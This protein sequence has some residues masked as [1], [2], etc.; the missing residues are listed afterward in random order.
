MRI[1]CVIGCSNSTLKLKKWQQNFCEQHNCNFGVGRCI[2]DPPFT[3]HSFPNKSKDPELRAK[4]IKLINR[5]EPTGKNWQPQKDSRICSEHFELGAT[6]PSLKLGYT[7]TNLSILKTRPPP[8]A[9]DLPQTINSQSNSRYNVVSSDKTNISSVKLPICQPTSSSD[10]VGLDHAYCT[11]EGACLN[12]FQQ[13]EKITRLQNEINNL[14]KKKPLIAVHNKFTKTDSKVRSN[15]GMPNRSALF[16]LFNYLK[17]RAAKL[18]YWEGATK[19]ISTKV[20]RHFPPN[21]TGPSQ[22]LFLMDEFVLVLLKLRLDIKFEFLAGLFN[23]SQ[24]TVS[25]IFNTWIKFLA[26]E[27][28]PLIF[29]PSKETIQQMQ[30]VSL[31]TK[32]PHLRCTLDCTEIFIEKPRHL[33]LQALTWSDYKQHNT[34]KFLIGISPNGCITF[35]SRCYGGRASDRHIVR[36]SSFLD[37]V[38][39]GDT[40]LADRGFPIAEDLL[41]RHAKLVIPPPGSG[42]QQMT[43]AN[44]RQT[45]TIANARIHVERAIN[46]IKWFA[47]LKHVLPITLVPVADEIVSVCATL[48]NL[49]PPLVK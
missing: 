19:V 29:W 33:E 49:L 23:I 41:L 37:K 16:S 25:K 46:R 27:L 44:V 34:L 6:V 20:A 40:I 18:K 45:K 3:L 15:T 5:K 38:S 26:H 11:T 10:D 2:C 17:P 30:P 35:L 7:P 36:E 39:P 21:K 48:C 22:K 13:E 31:A 14:K 28:K 8:K 42:I 9:R 4:W 32:Y 43:K 47:I 12:C 24:S 1:C